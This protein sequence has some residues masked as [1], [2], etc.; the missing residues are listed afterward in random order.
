MSAVSRRQIV[1][2][3]GA[4]GLALLAGCGRLPGQ[5]QAPT[6]VKVHRLGWLVADAEPNEDLRQALGELGY[7]EGQHV[8][9]EFARPRGTTS[10]CRRSPPSRFACPWICCSCWATRRPR[11]P[12]KP[13]PAFP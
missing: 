9:F 5:G 4:V 10:G 1:Q 3:V 6:P 13:R 2:G 11:P 8:V 12:S 7:V